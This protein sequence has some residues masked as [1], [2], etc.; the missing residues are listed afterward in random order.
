MLPQYHIILGAVF[1][2]MLFLIFPQGVGLIGAII[3]FLSS[4]LIDIDHYT[5][6]V[7]KKKDWS[8][9][10]A[11]SWHMKMRQKLLSLPRK[12]RNKVY[13]MLCHL[14]SIEL[15]LVLLSASIFIS[16][17]LLFVALGFA[18]HMLTDILYQPTYWDR[19]DKISLIFDYFKYKKLK[20]LED[21]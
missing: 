5:G 15:L 12:Q 11:I 10:N 13:G 9:K 3:F 20:N 1:S 7:I 4:F 6:Y 16:Q 2:I 14:H 18:F 21:I 19:F 8:L 17:Y